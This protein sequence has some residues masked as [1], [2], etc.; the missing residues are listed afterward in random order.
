MK[1]DRNLV[2]QAK[3]HAKDRPCLWLRG[4][5]YKDWYTT[6][7]EPPE[8]AA[9]WAMGAFLQYDVIPKDMA[10]QWWWYSDGSGGP[11]GADPR[12]RRVGWSLVGIGLNDNGEYELKAA[13]LGGLPGCIQTV[14]RSELYP[15]VVLAARVQGLINLSPYSL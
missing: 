10:E 6:V 4:L 2:E 11:E 8:E 12:M 7:P 1:L 14:P 13:L 15:L 3:I 9:T 5:P